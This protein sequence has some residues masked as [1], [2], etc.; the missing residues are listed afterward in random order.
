MITNQIKTIFVDE[1]IFKSQK[2]YSHNNMSVENPDFILFAQHGW[3]DNYR[4]I[5]DLVK[6]LV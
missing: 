3:A 4:A 2:F 6:R 5:A 1:N